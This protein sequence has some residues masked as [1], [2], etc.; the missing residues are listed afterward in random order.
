MREYINIAKK[1]YSGLM[2][3]W[4]IEVEYLK[5]D[6]FELDREIFF[7]NGFKAYL[8]TKDR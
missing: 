7:T 4:T 8:S 1:Y 6:I 5:V 2:I 3:L